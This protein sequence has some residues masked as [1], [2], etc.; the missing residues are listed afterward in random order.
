MTEP[1]KSVHE[2]WLAVMEDVREIRKTER[3][4]QQGFSFRGVDT[5]VNAVGPKLR[6]HG[7]IVIPNRIVEQLHRDVQTKNGGRQHEAIVTVEWLI[8]GPDGSTMTGQSVGESADSSDKAT[9]QAQSVA[10][11]VFL[12]ESLCVPTDDQDPD[13]NTIE[14]SGE[15]RANE[16]KPPFTDD[17]RHGAYDQLHGMLE[18]KGN[19]SG[20]LDWIMDAGINREN[21]TREQAAEWW[22]RMEKLPDAAKPAAEGPAPLPD[23]ERKRTWDSLAERHMALPE[24]DQEVIKQQ[25]AENFG[26]GAVTAVTLTRDMAVSWTAAIT[27]C[28]QALEAP[29]T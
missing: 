25:L 15:D 10:W 22:N 29:F 23:A 2:A 8:I 12:L 7:V 20:V 9:T 17:E 21:L 28:E 5:V 14:R 16:P 26:N 24:A 3:N 6:E 4:K 1:K 19:P 11:R 27:A 18:T 13:H